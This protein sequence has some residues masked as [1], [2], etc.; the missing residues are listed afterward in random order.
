MGAIDPI[1]EIYEICN[2]SP[3]FFKTLNSKSGKL[4]WDFE[5]NQQDNS[6]SYFIQSKDGEGGYPGNVEANV[7]Y[8]LDDQK[9]K[10][11]IRATTDCETPINMGQHNYFNLSSTQERPY[12]IC[13]HYH[14]FEEPQNFL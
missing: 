5:I 8:Q 4:I 6:V 3:G 10:I 7:K 11:E 9:L 12:N 1:Y 2:G 14:F 13:N